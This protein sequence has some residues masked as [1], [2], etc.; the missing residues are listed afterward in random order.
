MIRP[1]L[2]EIVGSWPSLFSLA[3]MSAVRRSCQTMARCTAC[4]VAR[5]HTTVVSRWLVM[6]IAAMSFAFRPAFSSASRQ[7]VDR[8]G[9]DVLGLVLDPARGREMLREFLL[10][11]GGDGDVAAEHDG[12]RGRGALIDGQH[13]GHGVASPG[14]F[15]LRKRQSDWGPKVNIRRRRASRRPCESEG[16]IATGAFI[17]AKSRL[18]VSFHSRAQRG[19]G[20]SRSQ[21]RARVTSP[22]S[23]RRRRPRWSGRS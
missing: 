17:V 22:R 1:V 15:W 21:G 5:S 14:G 4:P 2:A 7:T 8:R 20:P 18:P 11:G 9:P 23:S 12:A 6:P 19:M 10:R 3:Q 13:K 16:P